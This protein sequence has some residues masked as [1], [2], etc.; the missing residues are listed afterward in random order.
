LKIKVETSLEKTLLEFLEKHSAVFLDF[1]ESYGINKK[2]FKLRLVPVNFGTS[3]TFSYDASSNTLQITWRY[4]LKDSV[5][6]VIEGFVSGLVSS[7][8]SLKDT[9]TFKN[10]Q[11][12]YERE[13][14][15]DY[16]TVRM[17]YRLGLKD[18]I[19]KFNKTVDSLKSAHKYAKQRQESDKYL[20]EL[21]FPNVKEV[22][23]S[24]IEIKNRVLF[25]GEKKLQLTEMEQKFMGTLIKSFPYAATFDEIASSLWGDDAEKFSLQALARIQSNIRLKLKALGYGQLLSTLRGSGVLLNI[26]SLD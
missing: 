11:G 17:L 24:N 22:E 25:I 16:L 13:A 21:G 23:L 12:W 18:E 15:C 7:E 19:G 1:A 2:T 8:K 10:K 3:K 9:A 14:I 5:L 26:D 6:Y 4:D 20:A